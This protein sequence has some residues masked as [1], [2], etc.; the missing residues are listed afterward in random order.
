MLRQLRFWFR[1]SGVLTALAALTAAGLLGQVGL[2]APSPAGQRAPGGVQMGPQDPLLV[3]QR[4]PA[5]YVLGPNDIIAIHAPDLAGAGDS[6][7]AVS[8]DGYIAL[9]ELGRIRVAGLT[10]TQLENRIV[11]HLKSTVREPQVHVGILRFRS[12]LVFLIGAFVHPQAYP[13]QANRRLSELVSVAGGLLPNANRKVKVTRQLEFGRIPLEG[14]KVDTDRGVSEV[15]IDIRSLIETIGSPEDLLLQPS[16]IIAARLTEQVYVSGMVERPGALDL[17]DRDF[18][19][20]SQ[21]ISMAGLGP[22]A[23]LEKAVVLRPIEDTNRRASIPVN[24]KRIMQGR[25]RDFPLLP[26]DVLVVPAK[27]NPGARLLSFVLPAAASGAIWA[28]LR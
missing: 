28:L 24:L 22:D 23:K 15:E 14:A 7:I 9:P 1:R 6:P 26:N 11:D 2:Q 25:E 19:N 4:A 27:G 3:G 16:D 10:L 17:G 5:G 8:E 20:V 13:Y 12:D 21:A 18:L